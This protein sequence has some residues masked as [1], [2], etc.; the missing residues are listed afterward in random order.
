MRPGLDAGTAGTC[1]V[2]A[3]RLLV[4]VEGSTSTRGAVDCS[5]TR[6]LVLVEGPTS[7]ALVLRWLVEGGRDAAAARRRRGWWRCSGG[8]VDEETPGRSTRAVGA[9]RPQGWANG[10][11]GYYQQ[12]PWSGSPVARRRGCWSSSTRLDV[13]GAGVPGA[14]DVDEGA[15]STRG[16]VDC[17][18]TRALGLVEGLDVDEGMGDATGLGVTQRGGGQSRARTRRSPAEGL[19]FYKLP[20][21][22]TKNRDKPDIVEGRAKRPHSPSGH[23]P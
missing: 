21:S 3:S 19:V 14:L 23:G 1:A 20:L 12:F 15:T 22:K 6:L 9:R 16:A 17:S 4:L 10:N 2:P 13:E 7:R 18:S 11:C 5:A 8:V